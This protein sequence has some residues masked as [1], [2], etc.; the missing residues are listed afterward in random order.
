MAKKNK[1]RASSAL[2]TFAQLLSTAR[3][4]DDPDKLVRDIS[5]LLGVPDVRTARGLKEC[6]HGFGVI[7]SKLDEL[8]LQTRR[9]QWDRESAD[10]LAASVIFT[11]GRIA[12]DQV[13]RKR[14]FSETLV[15][16]TLSDITSHNN[17]AVLIQ[18]IRVVP[19]ILD[20]AEAN[21]S[22]IHVECIEAVVCI[23]V[24]CTL[25]IYTKVNPDPELVALVSITRVIEFLLAF[26]TPETH[27]YLAL[28][29][30]MTTERLAAVF[31]SNPDLISFLVAATRARDFHTRCFAQSS[32]VG[33]YSGTPW[34][35]LRPGRGQPECFSQM[36]PGSQSLFTQLGQMAGELLNLADNFDK[37][38]PQSHC[39]LGHALSDFMQRN[40]TT[41]RGYLQVPL[42]GAMT[43]LNLSPIVKAC[44]AALRRD[45]ATVRSTIAADMLR[46]EL[47][48]SRNTEKAAVFAHSCIERH[49]SVAYFYY[50][51]TVFPDTIVSPASSVC[52]AEKGLRCRPISDLIRQELGAYVAVFSHDTITLML[53]SSEPPNVEHLRKILALVEKGLSYAG[54]FLDSAPLDHPRA[55]EMSAVF[56]LFNLMSKGDVLTAKQLE[57]THAKFAS[58]CKIARDNILFRLS[59][60]CSALEL[61]FD[62]MPAAWERWGSILSRT[63]P[64]KPRRKQTHYSNGDQFLSW[65]QTLAD[66]TPD[67][68]ESEIQGRD[69]GVRSKD[70]LGVNARGTVTM[71]ARGTIGKFIELFVKPSRS[72]CGI[73]A[74]SDS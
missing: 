16:K 39:Q 14:I 11:Y 69:P 70:A 68:L 4:E 47:L 26:A 6:H 55:P 46:F 51:M 17:A 33:I 35:Q 40:P 66:A 64:T 8:Y 44:E 57:T 45:G 37:N 23:L 25:P 1:S 12:E 29:C 10:R 24:Y 5:R 15:L 36:H 59:K 62:R 20:Y 72:R 18:V 60:E 42:L 13:L 9:D 50:A 27:R 31:L 43:N 58:A 63:E 34:R 41:I 71:L 2:P 49:P 48:L 53:N 22:K 30:Y 3:S 73:G 21:Q 61:I 32:L 19:T 52:F 65:L 74:K 7:S 38:C 56:A 28:F 54:T 67:A